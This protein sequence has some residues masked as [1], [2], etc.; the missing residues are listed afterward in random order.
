MK[1]RKYLH[2]YIDTE[3]TG[4]EESIHHAHQIAGLIVSPDFQILE[5]FNLEF[6][7]Y[8]IEGISEEAL[9][10]TRLT[11]EQLLARPMS[12]KEA[13]SK[14]KGILGKHINQY[15][16]ADKAHLVGFRV[17]F[18]SDFLRK[19][20]NCCGDNYFGSWFWTPAVDLMY[21]SAWLLG[22]GRGALPDFK[23][24]T[25]CQAAGI[26]WSDDNAHDALYDVK[27]TYEL[28]R[29]LKSNFMA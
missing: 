23:L 14:L 26:E 24:G 2:V 27:K 5:S 12:Y 28:D 29:Y 16:K 4:T 20:F 3:T 11:R 8:S 21:V 1:E 13:H 7:P 18:D 17:E 22:D 9:A 19:L 15:D 10:K 6:V 25:V